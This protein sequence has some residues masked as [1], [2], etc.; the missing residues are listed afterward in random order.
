MANFPAGIP[1]ATPIDK[2]SGQF[3]VPWQQ[4]FLSIGKQVSTVAAAQ[5]AAASSPVTLAPASSL[6]PQSF[7]EL[8]A[9]SFV[10]LSPGAVIPK[11]RVRCSIPDLEATQLDLYWQEAAQQSDIVESAWL[12]Y[13]RIGGANT[14]PFTPNSLID[15]EVLNAPPTAAG[16]QYFAVYTLTNGNTVSAPSSPS[17]GLTWPPLSQ[18]L[19]DPLNPVLMAS[20]D[21]FGNVTKIRVSTGFAQPLDT[22]PDGFA[23]MYSMN[24]VPNQVSI[25][26]GETGTDL[27]I[28]SVTIDAQGTIPILAGSTVSE[29][30]NTTLVAPNNTDLPQISRYW[31]QFGQSSWRK[32]TGITATS[33]LFDP[34]FDIA[35]SAGETLNWVEVAWF[36]DRGPDSADTYGV[37]GESYRLAVLSNGAEYE[38]LGWG[39]VYQAID[40]TFHI[41]GC[42]RGMEGTVPLNADGLTLHY[43]PAPGAGTVILSIPAVNFTLMP[44]GTWSADAEVNVSVPAGWSVSLS[45]CTFKG[46]LGK[47][48]RSD[49]VPLTYGGAF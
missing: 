46:V 26:A 12:H 49:I 15:V 1:I 25:S 2:T 13:G 30:V 4:F 24:S 14:T 43:Y 41:G 35:P 27:T 11:F 31:A 6:V 10:A 5:K 17:E 34:P 28:N 19:V 39:E 18:Y 37:P 22:L 7:P 38:V 20:M 23:V 29:I 9:P 47:I 45:C 8:P 40:G 3:T 44:N 32:A 33:F 42:S 21:N 48:I 16:K 36:D